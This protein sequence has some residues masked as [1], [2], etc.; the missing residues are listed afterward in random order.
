M[1]GCKGRC[2]I[3]VGKYVRMW[4][5]VSVGKY[6]GAWGEVRKEVGKGMRGVGEGKGRF[7]RCK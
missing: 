5:K 1:L 6:V 7:G 4:G 3:G 2:G